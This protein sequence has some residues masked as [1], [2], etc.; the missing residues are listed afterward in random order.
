MTDERKYIVRKFGPLMPHFKKLTMPD[1][2]KKTFID[3]WRIWIKWDQSFED[4][5]RWSAERTDEIDNE[6]AIRRAFEKKKTWPWPKLFEER[7]AL[8]ER[9]FNK[10]HGKKKYVLFKN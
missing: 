1:G 3:C 7:K 5:T 8:K 10:Y 9:G 6:E 2:T 4:G